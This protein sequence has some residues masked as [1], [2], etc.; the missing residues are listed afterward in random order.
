MIFRCS[1]A[2][3]SHSARIALARFSPLALVFGV[4]ACGSAQGEAGVYIAVAPSPVAASTTPVAPTA[5]PDGEPSEVGALQESVARRLAKRFYESQGEFAGQYA[6]VDVVRL[7]LVKRSA[8]RMDAHVAYRFRCLRPGACCCGDD[9]SDQRIFA[10]LHS[11]TRGW[12]VVAMGDHM[13]A[14]F[15]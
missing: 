15:D 4:V 14:R 12:H 10:F 7:R 1:T 8:R 3:R 11:E 6:L 13:S 5:P 2:A 9:G